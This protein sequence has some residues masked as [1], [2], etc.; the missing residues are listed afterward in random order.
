M[1]AVTEEERQTVLLGEIRDLLREIRDALKPPGQTECPKC[2]STYVSRSRHLQ[3]IACSKGACLRWAR[4]KAE[5]GWQPHSLYEC[6]DC[7]HEWVEA[8][9]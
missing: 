3:Q 4:D 2:G 8:D 7:D 1:T 9:E 6:G 5:P